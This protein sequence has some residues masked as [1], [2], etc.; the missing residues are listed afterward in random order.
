MKPEPKKQP[1]MQALTARLKEIQLSFSDIDSKLD[2]LWENFSVALVDIFSHEEYNP[3]S[4]S[5]EKERMDFSDRYYQLKSFLMDKLKELQ[6]PQELENSVGITLQTFNGNI[7]EWFSFRDLFNSLIHWKAELPE[8]EK[9]HYLKGCLQGEPRA[10][11][12]PLPITKANY[13]VAWDLLLKRYNNSKQLKKR[14]VQALFKLPTLTKESGADLHILL[15]GFERI[16]QT[17]DQVIQPTDYKDLLLVDILT[18]RLDPVTRWGWEEA[19]STKLQDTLDDLR[20]FLQRRVQVLDC[21][22]SRSTDTR[23]AAQMQQSS[24]QKPQQTKT[25]YSSAQVSRARCALCSADHFLYYCKEFQRLSIGDSDNFLKSNGPC[26]NCF[27]AGH[28]AKDCQSKYSCKGR[29]HT[30]VCFK[31]AKEKFGKNMVVAGGN[32]PFTPEDQPDSSSSSS[33]HVARMAAT[34]SVVSASTT[35]QH[36]HQVLLATAVVLIEDDKGNRIPA[37][38]LLDSGSKSNFITENLCQQMK[39]TRDQV[40]ISILGIGQTGDCEPS[41]HNYQQA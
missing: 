2:E 19:S 22:L 36:S 14:Q 29:H 15:E 13:Q 33:K 6:K 4:T 9:F 10:L 7:D 11:I 31:S 5:V 38:A 20:E 17:L 37:R 24:K 39:A 27:R 34:E 12:D 26:R 35:Q 30:L 40:D 1:T 21:S 25:S 41:N 3:D 23:G 16:V 28:Q 18:T 8:V 32:V